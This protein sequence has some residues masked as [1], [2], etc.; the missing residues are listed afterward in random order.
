[1][2]STVV[3]SNL[4]SL[5][6]IDPTLTAANIIPVMEVV[7]DWRQLASDYRINIPIAIR[8]RITKH[9]ATNK[10]RSRAAGEWWVHTYHSPSWDNLARALYHRGEDRAL[11][12]MT[13]YLPKGVYM[14]RILYTVVL[15]VSVSSA[16][17]C[18]LLD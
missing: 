3:K 15:I 12:K 16:T 9:H 11:E 10:M 5:P 2:L 7:G 14:E 13:Q 1:M 17:S 4:V 8:E 6:C 18:S